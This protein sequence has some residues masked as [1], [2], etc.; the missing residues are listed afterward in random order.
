MA[1]LYFGASGGSNYLFIWRESRLKSLEL[2]I[3]FTIFQQR[4]ITLLTTWPIIT[5]SSEWFDHMQ[6]II[7]I[8]CVSIVAIIISLLS[9]TPLSHEHFVISHYI[10][11]QL[12]IILKC[13]K[14][15]KLEQTSKWTV[16]ICSYS[17][18]R[19]PPTWSILVYIKS[20]LYWIPTL[21]T[22]QIIWWIFETTMTTQL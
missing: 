4:Y 12:Y 18:H 1:F 2:L 16:P 3:Q 15:N 20:R 7:R 9:Y 17:F 22:V 14:L 19:L 11:M 5:I 13:L 21:S 10:N 6:K 8:V